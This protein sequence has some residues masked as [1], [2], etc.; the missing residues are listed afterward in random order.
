M[1]PAL[2]YTHALKHSN[3]SL[4][5]AWTCKVIRVALN[6]MQELIRV[7][8]CRNTGWD[9]TVADIAG[10]DWEALAA[11]PN[12]AQQYELLKRDAKEA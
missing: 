4:D 3:G 10:P 7:E 12:L 6:Y 1:S 2:I 8:R 5:P 9:K 11:S